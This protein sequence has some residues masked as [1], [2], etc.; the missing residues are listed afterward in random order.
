MR[1]LIGFNGEYKVKTLRD[2][3]MAEKLTGKSKGVLF[4]LKHYWSSSK[5]EVQDKIKNTCTNLGLQSII[6]SQEEYSI[7]SNLKNET[8]Y[9]L[10]DFL[11]ERINNEIKIGFV[12]YGCLGRCCISKKSVVD[13]LESFQ[14]LFSLDKVYAI[15][16]TGDFINH[17][18]ESQPNLDLNSKLIYLE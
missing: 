16:S 13:N 5:L 15:V 8:E 11:L 9:S 1:E 7:I 18:E 12:Y 14:D 2:V 6:T 4:T 3:L 17:A 10:V